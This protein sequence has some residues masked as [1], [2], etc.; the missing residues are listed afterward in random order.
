MRT[1]YEADVRSSSTYP[2]CGGYKEVNAFA[3]REA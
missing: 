1:N 2:G 3:V